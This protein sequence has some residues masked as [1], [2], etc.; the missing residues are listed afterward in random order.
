M[1]Q[2]PEM[3]S[4]EASIYQTTTTDIELPFTAELELSG[5]MDRIVVDHPDQVVAGAVPAIVLDDMLKYSD[6]QDNQLLNE[7]TI[8]LKLK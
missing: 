3:S 8:K 6:N 1:V 7:A 4:M 2:L 5:S